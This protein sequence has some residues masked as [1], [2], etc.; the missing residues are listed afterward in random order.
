MLQTLERT[1]TYETRMLTAADRE[2]LQALCGQQGLPL[3]PPRGLEPALYNGQLLGDLTQSGALR[4]A[5]ALLPLYADA[6]LPASLRAAGYGADGQG[7]VLTPPLC[8]ARYP[9]LRQFLRAALRLAAARYASYHVWAVQPL[10]PEALPAGEDLCAQY[11]SAGMTLRA[12]RP[13]AGA[14]MMVFS[15][16]GL[17]HWREPRRRV[18][19]S[20]PALPRLLER[21]YAVGDFGWGP[22]GMELL[23]RDAQ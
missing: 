3:L 11:L 10:D 15:A 13:M 9:R 22:G 23:L 12:V 4:A 5:L 21:G 1:T 14:V 17:P 8:A 19:L 18:H 2:A 16:R 6:V 7:A 20:D